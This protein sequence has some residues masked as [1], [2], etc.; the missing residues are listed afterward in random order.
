MGGCIV[1]L[2]RDVRGDGDEEGMDVEERMEDVEGVEDGEGDVSL[3]LGSDVSLV[4]DSRIICSWHE[5]GPPSSNMM[6]RDSMNLCVS[7]CMRWKA[8][9]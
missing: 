1:H 6:S 8:L 2:G 3:E 5:L 4:L 7:W 9:C